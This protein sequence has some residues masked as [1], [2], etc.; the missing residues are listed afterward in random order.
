M[1]IDNLSEKLKTATSQA[2]WDIIMEHYLLQAPLCVEDTKDVQKTSMLSKLTDETCVEPITDDTVVDFE[3]SSLLDL[4]FSSK[5]IP[6]HSFY[7]G[8]K[9]DPAAAS[10]RRKRLTGTSSTMQRSSSTADESKD[11][12]DAS[13]SAAEWKARI[14]LDFLEL[15]DKG[16]LSDTYSHKLQDWLEFGVTLSTPAVRKHHVTITSKHLTGVTIKEIQ[17]LISQLSR[18]SAKAFS[19]IS[20]AGSKIPDED[21]YAPH[22]HTNFT[23]KCIIISRNFEQWKACVAFNGS[24]DFPTLFNTNTMKHMQKFCPSVTNNTFI[25]RQKIFWAL[26]QS[27]C[28][29]LL[30]A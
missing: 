1:N 26:I 3:C 25:P 4:S 2:T 12:M 17:S 6:A 5:N 30:H 24:V 23:Q 18:E 19:P 15:G 27:D 22:S 8:K 10:K 21:I 16:I 14:K 7:S 29:S 13:K 9:S 28:V 11:S 20:E